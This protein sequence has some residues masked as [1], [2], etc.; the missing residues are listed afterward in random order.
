MSGLV[1]RRAGAVLGG[2]LCP[3]NEPPR[4][5][6]GENRNWIMP[7]H[8]SVRSGCGSPVAAVVALRDGFHLFD[9]DTGAATFLAAPDHSIPGTRFNDGKVAPDGRFF[10]GNMDEERLSRPIAALYR[11][12]SGWRR[13]PRGR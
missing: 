4:P 3:V 7:G 13:A 9:F 10:A 12:R 2:Y 1:R 5:A 8:E 11:P 6:T